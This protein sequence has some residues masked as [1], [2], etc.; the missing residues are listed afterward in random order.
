M[1]VGHV[2]CALL[3]PARRVTPERGW[4]HTTTPLPPPSRGTRPAITSVARPPPQPRL[5]T[6]RCLQ[7]L[8][9]D[10][11]PRPP[12]AAGRR[13]ALLRLCLEACALV[14]LH[15][16]GEEG[17]RV[18]LRGRRQLR[19]SPSWGMRGLRRTSH[20]TRGTRA[21]A[22]TCAAGAAR[23]AAAAGLSEATWTYRCAAPSAA[24]CASAAAI[25]DAATPRRR[26]AVATHTFDR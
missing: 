18:P 1:S 6:P 12:Q 7:A 19:R 15:A 9:E 21:L 16:A 11:A 22:S 3:C 24:A 20:S 23:T 10:P 13:L 8:V 2:R 5:P 14:G 25:S 4:V 17:R 26:A